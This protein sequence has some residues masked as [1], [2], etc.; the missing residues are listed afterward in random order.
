MQASTSRSQQISAIVE[1]RRPR[2]RQLEQV[3]QN[4]QKLAETLEN[5]EEQR[6]VILETLSDP[7]I[8]AQLQL[9]ELSA[10]RQKIREEQ[11]ALARL[12]TRF[13]RA[14][15]NIGVVGL[16]RQ[17]KSR[18]LQTISGLSATEIP[19][20][21]GSHCTGVRSLICHAPQVESFA[22]ISFY[23]EKEFLHDVI[24]P[25][26]RDEREGGLRLGFPPPTLNQFAELALPNLPED[27]PGR[28]NPQTRYER[29]KKLHKNLSRYRTLLNK[30]P[31]TIPPTQI[32]DYVAQQNLNDEPLFNYLA[33]RE[34][35][36]YCSFPFEDV[37][38]VA[39][40]DMPG[41]GDTG[42]GDEARLLK[43]LS[44]DVDAVLFVRSP[45]PAGDNWTPADLALYDL[46]QQAIS[47]LPLENWSFLA[48][49]HN[50]R[51]GDNLH[52]CEKFA[53]SVRDGETKI[54]TSQLEIVDCSDPDEVRQKLLDP[55]LSHL[56]DNL[57]QLDHAYAQA[58]QESLHK[59]QT[60]IRTQLGRAT[61]ILNNV[62]TSDGEM[63]QFDR[64]FDSLWE[65]L[66]DGVE[67]LLKELR[68]QRK[69]PDEE[70]ARQISAVLEKCR[71]APG[72]PT[73]EQIERRRNKV[74]A[75]GTAYNMYLD[76][77]RTRLTNHFIELDGALKLTT[78]NLKQRV[79]AV[80]AAPDA[81]GL[82]RLSPE[83]GVGL[84]KR[85]FELLADDA[86][87]AQL[88][89]AFEVL[90]DFEL[91]YRGFIQY[92]VR[93]HLDCLTPD[94]TRTRVDSDDTPADVLGYLQNMYEE[95]IYNVEAAFKKWLADPNKANF[96]IV[97]E[98]IDQI[99]RAEGAPQAWRN[100]YRTVRAEVWPNEFKLWSARSQ[101]QKQ[102][103]NYLG[104]AE[105]TN[106]PGKLT[107]L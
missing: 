41:L 66:T 62:A 88:H 61:R 90:L 50:R 6:Q 55:L 26:Y 49:N 22:E 84:L 38:K 42:L 39:L 1:Q 17:G 37:E 92:R 44:E 100:F 2:V 30:A 76:E 85:I 58:C 86:D 71:T 103:Q 5:L 4:L 68:E 28:A 67:K 72:L 82:A 59:L 34:A 29:L 9:I 12:K 43:A 65:Q 10:F 79:A 97:E 89:R 3:E 13:G 87:L 52:N 93:E 7:A 56:A 101:L 31:S 18:L 14:T 81:G 105:E 98:F 16:A 8:A 83:S 60:E 48:L 69:E 74:N 11:A 102:W 21:D 75:L 104:Q 99:L 25:Y 47:E 46:A 54:R 80:L 70:F 36:I 64:Y 24:A 107:F 78:T 95:A 23:S 40:L 57:A 91:S 94:L 35:K 45:K 27:L 77:I 96:A 15:L 20:G 51:H 33:V 53:Q 19:D 106:Q 73:V 32:R 63:R